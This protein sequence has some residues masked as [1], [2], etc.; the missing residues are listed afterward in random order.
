MKKLL[1][2]ILL[3]SSVLANSLISNEVMKKS[4]SMDRYQWMNLCLQERRNLYCGGKKCPVSIEAP[5]RKY[6]WS[7]RIYNNVVD[8]CGNL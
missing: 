7:C 6:C 3:S 8:L 1:V 4:I 5:W 2:L